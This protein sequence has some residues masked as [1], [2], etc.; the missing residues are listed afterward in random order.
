[1]RIKFLK[2]N[3]LELRSAWPEF[4]QI[5]TCSFHGSQTSPSSNLGSVCHVVPQDGSSLRLSSLLTFIQDGNPRLTGGSLLCG[6]SLSVLPGEL[7]LPGDG[8]V[9]VEASI[10]WLVFHTPAGQLWN[11]LEPIRKIIR[12]IRYLTRVGRISSKR[13][14]ASAWNLEIGA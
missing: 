3:C 14:F 5:L 11:Y 6:R 12:Q 7:V 13:K 1:M 2:I 4:C 9:E 10:A 8:W